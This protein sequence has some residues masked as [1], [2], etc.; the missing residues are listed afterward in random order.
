METYHDDYYDE[1]IVE[2]IP[3]GEQFINFNTKKIYENTTQTETVVEGQIRWTEKK[4]IKR[5][6][7]SAY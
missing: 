5:A 2:H 3:I 7:A 1:E 4:T 6:K